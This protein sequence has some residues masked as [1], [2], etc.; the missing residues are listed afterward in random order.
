[1]P[2]PLLTHITQHIPL[3]P[4]EEARV[5]EAITERQIKRK[6]LLLRSGE[7]CRHLYFVLE[8]S[9]RAFFINPDGKES[10]VM[11]ALPDWWITD[12]P[13]FV[14]QTAAMVSIEALEDSKIL[15]IGYADLQKLYEM[16]PAFERLFRILMQNAYVREQLRV[17]DNL[18]LTTLERYDRF[19]QK[20]P[21]LVSRITQKQIAS[22]LGV[23][24]EFL[25]SV[26]RKREA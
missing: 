4:S 26:I 1:M 6:S 23:T 9:L 14:R 11:F 7:A 20:Y 12:M 17:L 3:T 18:S 8:G 13:C 5:L 21:Q 10:T 16:V 19:V 15:Q 24:P 25:S 22:Y 2:S